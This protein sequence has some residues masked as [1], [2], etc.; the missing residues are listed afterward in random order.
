MRRERT[1]NRPHQ[2]REPG[3]RAAPSAALRSRALCRPTPHARGCAGRGAR[4]TGGACARKGRG[5]GVR[6][7][8]RWARPRARARAAPFPSRS[9]R[10]ASPPRRERAPPALAPGLSQFLRAAHSP[11]LLPQPSS[12]P[13][14]SSPQTQPRPL[15]VSGLLPSLHHSPSFSLPS[16]PPSTP[17]KPGYEAGGLERELE[18]WR[19]RA[20][21]MPS[22]AP[23]APVRR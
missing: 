2:N 17:R 8:S 22:T 12:R 19:F 6:R 7:A 1:P 21:I 20:W 23:P 4:A 3:E 15:S 5:G 18:K 11:A 16:L 10:A 9:P 14:L 13:W